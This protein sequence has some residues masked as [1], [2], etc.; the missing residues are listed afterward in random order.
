MGRTFLWS[1]Y[2]TIRAY[3]WLR[4]AWVKLDLDISFKMPIR[5]PSPTVQNSTQLDVDNDFIGCGFIGGFESKWNVYKG[6]G[7]FS[8]AS[9]S[10]IYGS[11]SERTKQKFEIAPAGSPTLFKQ[12]LRAKNETHAVKGVFDIALGIKWEADYYKENH[13]YLWAGYDFFYWPNVTQKTINQATR[14]RDRAD[15]SYEGFIAG[16][17]M[18]F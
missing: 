12:T 15:L 8:H 16:A 18:D 5:V 14:S 2:F 9:A 6:F 4:G 3:S 17:R 10:L 1:R 13:I 11:S 7:L